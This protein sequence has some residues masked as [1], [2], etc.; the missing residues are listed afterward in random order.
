MKKQTQTAGEQPAVS[1]PDIGELKSELGLAPPKTKFKLKEG[2]FKRPLPR[3]PLISP[4]VY[5]KDVPPFATGP[6]IKIP[7]RLPT[8]SSSYKYEPSL[9]EKM[10]VPCAYLV[11]RINDWIHANPGKSMMASQLLDMME[12]QKFGILQHGFHPNPPKEVVDYEALEKMPLLELGILLG[13]TK[14]PNIKDRINQIFDSRKPKS[15]IDPDSTPIEVVPKEIEP[16]SPS[17]LSPTVRMPADHVYGPGEAEAEAAALADALEEEIE[18]RLKSKKKKPKATNKV[19]ETPKD[20]L[21]N[22]GMNRESTLYT[23][24]TKETKARKK[25]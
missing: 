4:K 24:P 13:T 8:Q 25:K 23:P 18:E 22:S 5:L 2:T 19:P 7:T 12:A 15:T 11:G 17:T 16:P 14:D 10:M 20:N 9:R 3:E 21:V 6:S 1:I